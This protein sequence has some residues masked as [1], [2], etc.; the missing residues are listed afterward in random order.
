[1]RN[2]VGALIAVLFVFT[3]IGRSAADTIADDFN[4]GVLDLSLWQT[5][6]T[7]SDPSNNIKDGSVVESG[8]VVTLTN[9]GVLNTFQEFEPSPSNPVTIEFDF[10]F[11]SGQRSPYDHDAHRGG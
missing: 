8:G 2:K 4:D 3:F 10:S 1:M 9:R 6:T 11:L 7:N 5:V